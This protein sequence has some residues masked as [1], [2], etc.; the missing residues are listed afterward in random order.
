MASRNERCRM[1]WRQQ[2]RSFFEIQGVKRAMKF[3]KGWIEKFLSTDSRKAE[4]RHAPGLV[5]YF[6][7]GGAPKAHEIENI[8]ETGFYLLTKERWYPGTVV[9]MT[10]QKPG[11][12]DEDASVEHH[13]AVQS[14]VVRVGEDGVGLVFIP[15][16]A[17]NPH[18]KDGL[19]TKLVGKKGLQKFLERLK[20][21]HG[22]VVT[23]YI[24]RG[25][26]T[27]FVE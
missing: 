27:N 1:C 13:I 7:D 11:A 22:Q 18:Q 8:S 26:G 23:G 17:K 21:D 6:W 9:T 2:T 10:L 20:S 24:R 14:Q 12:T 19:K 25:P 3:G 5:A 4:R 16:D 15:F